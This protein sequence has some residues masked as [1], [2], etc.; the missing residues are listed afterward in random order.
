[1]TVLRAI[2]LV[3]QATLS[4][5]AST[6]PNPTATPELKSQGVRHYHTETHWLIRTVPTIV[7]VC[8]RGPILL[9]PQ[10]IQLTCA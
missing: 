4:L 3:V 1:M 6:P 10:L 8:A 9:I 2:T 7:E 5:L